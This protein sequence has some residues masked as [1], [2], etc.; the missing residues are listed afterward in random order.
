MQSNKTKV[1]GTFDLESQRSS[2]TFSQTMN[3]YKN[4]DEIG[5]KRKEAKKMVEREVR[6]VNC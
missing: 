3:I 2:K 5:L 6:F 1:Y 4:I